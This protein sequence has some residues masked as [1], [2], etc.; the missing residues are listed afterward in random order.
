MFKLELRITS[1]EK[2]WDYEDNKIE[3]RMVR[4]GSTNTYTF[5]CPYCNKKYI[6]SPECIARG[7]WCQCRKRKTE[8]KTLSRLIDIHGE[9]NIKSEYRLDMCPN[10]RYD[11]SIPHLNIIIEIDGPQHFRNISNWTPFDITQKSDVYKIDC[12]IK[13]GYTIIHIDQEDI[14]YDRIDWKYILSKYIYKHTSPKCYLISS[15]KIYTDT[16]IENFVIENNI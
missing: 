5:N 3:P 16:I 14:W 12:A 9:Q 15:N 8:D 2:F 6:T 7:H 13:S 11:I 4:L 1:N 10:K